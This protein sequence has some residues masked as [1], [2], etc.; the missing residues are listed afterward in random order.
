MAARPVVA[1]DLDGTL[2]RGDTLLPFLRRLCGTKRTAGAVLAQAAP[3]SRSLLAGSRHD[4]KEA[5]LVRLLA[6]RELSALRA[7]AE[8]FAA[9]IV[10]RRLRP[11]MRD[12]VDWHRR[13]GHRLVVVSA[14]PELYVG[15]ISRLLRFDAAL[16]TR[17]EVGPDGCLT[18][19][20]QGRNCRGPEKVV[21]LRAWMGEGASLAYA[22][23]DSAG[24][25][26]LLE[27]AETPLRVGRRYIPPVAGATAAARAPRP[28]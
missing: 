10:A 4:A 13:A 27:L 26:E 3:I 19:R 28:C 18:G 22:N 1:F 5:L 12:R 25:H 23:G 15:P 11:G 17:L 24:D 14:S 20:I 21:R 8:A 6:G 7:P 16:A 2:T 9:H